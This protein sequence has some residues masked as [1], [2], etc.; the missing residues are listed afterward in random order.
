MKKRVY[1]ETTIVSYATALPSFDPVILDRQRR[2]QIWWQD[3]RDQYE[4]FASQIV[5]Q[6]AGGGDP[7]AAARRLEMLANVPLL[8]IELSTMDTARDMIRR[9]LLP[10]NAATDAAH[11]AIAA[12]SGMDVL[13]TWNCTHLANTDILLGVSR[14]LRSHGWEPPIVCTPFEM[15]GEAENVED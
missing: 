2:T 11:L 6:E 4:L 1:I 5:L 8:D 3:R 7:D 9:R 13:L 14:Y 15:L 10:P 12:A